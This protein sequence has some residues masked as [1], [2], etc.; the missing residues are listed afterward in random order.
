MKEQRDRLLIDSKK[1]IELGSESPALACDVAVVCREGAVF[2][3]L[4]SSEL[5]IP[6]VWR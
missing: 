2:A 4:G 3:V 6:H 5:T 1:Q